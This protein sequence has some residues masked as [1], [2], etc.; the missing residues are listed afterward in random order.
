MPFQGDSHKQNPPTNVGG[1]LKCG[2]PNVNGDLID[3]DAQ[4]ILFLVHL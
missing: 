2:S 4:Y 1:S 3:Y